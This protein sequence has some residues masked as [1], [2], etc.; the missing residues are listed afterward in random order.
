MFTQIGQDAPSLRP[1]TSQI[2]PNDWRVLARYWYPVAVAGDVKGK[3]VKGKLLDVELVVY[4]VEGQIAVAEDVCPHRNVRLSAG[5]IVDDRLVCPFHGLAYDVSGQCTKIPALARAAKIPTK[6]RLRSFRAETRYGLVWV[7]LDPQSSATIPTFPRANEIGDERLA[8]GTV[9]D[10]PVAAPHQIENYLDIAHLPFVHHDSLAGD[11]TAPVQT[12]RIE[13][14]ADGLSIHASS[15]HAFEGGVSIRYDYHNTVYLPF[16]V[17]TDAK[18]SQDVS[19]FHSAYQMWNIAAPISAHVCRVY[20]VFATEGASESNESRPAPYNG[21]QINL[22]DIRVLAELA[23]PNYPLEDK[24][25]LH[26]PGDN[27]S[28]EYRKCLRNLGLGQR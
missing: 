2:S 23:R 18:S 5:R 4:R 17:Y 26:I 19:A 9:R 16:S 8:F 11:P 12:P 6:Y 7:C 20:F 10:W 13:Q 1:A 15:D 14:T 24:L 3:P 28:N 22:E 25:L 21:D 27:I